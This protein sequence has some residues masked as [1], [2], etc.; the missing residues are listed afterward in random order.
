MEAD[1]RAR[2]NHLREDGREE[3]LVRC[4]DGGPS[5][6]DASSASPFEGVVADEK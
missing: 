1:E 5:E 6:T 2:D 3:K 4:D